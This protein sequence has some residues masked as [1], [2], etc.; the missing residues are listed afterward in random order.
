MTD[1][2]LFK[3]ML[4]QFN[5]EF[6]EDDWEEDPSGNLIM[7][8]IDDSKFGVYNHVVDFIFHKSTGRFVQ[9]GVIN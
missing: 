3:M 2:E 4:N 7:I 9:Y 8:E 6:V 1:L 5:I